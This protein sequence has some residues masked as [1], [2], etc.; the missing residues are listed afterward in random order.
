M[1]VKQLPKDSFVELGKRSLP[2]SYVEPMEADG[3]DDL[4][5]AF[6]AIFAAVDEA[7]N[8]GTQGYFLREHSDQTA[9]PGSGPT[10]ARGFLYVARGGY[11]AGELTLPVGTLIEAWR[12]DS[13]GAET[14]VGVYR[15]VLEL[16]LAEGSGSPIALE[17]EATNVGWFGNLE[18]NSVTMRFASVGAI[19]VPAEVTASGY[20][21]NNA[22]TTEGYSDTWAGDDSVIGRYCTVQPIAGVLLDTIQPFP[23]RIVSRTGFII[24]VS[25]VPESSDIGKGCLVT[26]VEWNDLGLALTQPEAIDGGNGGALDARGND[27]NSPRINGESDEKYVNRLEAMTDTVTPNAVI[28]A[29]DR[30]LSPYGIA[31][32]FVEARD[33]RGLGGR[34]W[35]MHPWDFGG[36]A[37]IPGTQE[38]Y[39]VQ[40]AVWLS[41]SQTRRYF[42]IAVAPSIE[43]EPF[44]ASRLWN[45]VRSITLS[46]N[47][48]S[49]VIDDSL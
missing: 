47:S 3:T 36:I 38:P 5:Y 35:D 24:G 18:A 9:E 49:I 28:R 21:R 41:A 26:V 19:K 40:G 20:L 23:R 32:R 27:Y 39:Q 30:E 14:L 22:H 2:G 37:P 7:T 34:V 25:P 42:L 13:Y 44:V 8:L 6:G 43:N 17:I 16:V 12:L 4:F 48:F 46:G 11:S 29:I 45:A 1:P 15:T 31:W 10:K 33:P